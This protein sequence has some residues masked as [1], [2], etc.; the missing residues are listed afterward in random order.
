M[1]DWFKTMEEHLWF[2][3]DKKGEEEARFIKKAVKRK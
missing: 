1:P 2:L 3:P